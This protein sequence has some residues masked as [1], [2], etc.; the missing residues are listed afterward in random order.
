MIKTYYLNEHNKES[1]KNILL[2]IL[3]ILE[4]EKLFHETYLTEHG[5]SVFT[6]VVLDKH[7]NSPVAGFFGLATSY[8]YDLSE[9]LLQIVKQIMIIKKPIIRDDGAIFGIDIVAELAKSD[10]KYLDIFSDF[11]MR[12]DY[13][14]MS[15]PFERLIELSFVHGWNEKI[16]ALT[17]R[18]SFNSQAL[19][20]LFPQKRMV[21]AIKKDKFL[22]KFLEIY[23]EEF[24]KY[25]EDAVD[26]DIMEYNI[27]KLKTAMQPKWL[28]KIKSIFSK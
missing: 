22:D 8:K 5:Y 15:E 19:N 12:D 26:K 23:Q 13:K 14:M 20:N 25:G 17:C 6:P 16:Y 2:E 10:I 11:V 28:K 27:E 9:I 1:V 3:D 21:D 4:N 7:N 24:N 18:L